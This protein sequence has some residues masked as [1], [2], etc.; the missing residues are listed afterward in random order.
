MRPALRPPLGIQRLK[1]RPIVGHEDSAL[2]ASVAEL[3][4]IWNAPVPAV[5]LEHRHSIH[6]ASAQALGDA[7]AQVPIE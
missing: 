7:V 1:I 3:P 5:H 2:G 4:L 6:I